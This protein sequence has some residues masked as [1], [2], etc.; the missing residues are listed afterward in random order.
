MKVDCLVYLKSRG[1]LLHISMKVYFSFISSLYVYTNYGIYFNESVNKIY[2]SRIAVCVINDGKWLVTCSWLCLLLWM[3]F[4]NHQFILLTLFYKKRTHPFFS[5]YFMQSWLMEHKVRSFVVTEVN[6]G[7]YGKKWSI[8]S[9]NLN[10][11]ELFATQLW[12][13]IVVSNFYF[14]F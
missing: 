3:L 14:I 5:G 6:L 11:L 12:T 1:I 7:A 13:I 9:K 10:I 8:S 2:K 4:D